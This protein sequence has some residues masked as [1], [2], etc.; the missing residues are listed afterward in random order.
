MNEPI[1]IT[2]ETHRYVGMFRPPWEPIFEEHW[3]QIMSRDDDSVWSAQESALDPECE[4]KFE[5][6]SELRQAYLAGDFDIPQY[7]LKET[8]K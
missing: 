1:P 8:A 3:R 5:N 4:W 2:A 6:E 7:E